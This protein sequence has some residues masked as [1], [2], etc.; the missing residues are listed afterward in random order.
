MNVDNLCLHQ[1]TIRVWRQSSETRQ[2][3]IDEEKQNFLEGS[4]ENMLESRQNQNSDSP[5]V[6]TLDTFN[7]MQS[8]YLASKVKVQSNN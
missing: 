2:A 3:A 6:G 4:F 7:A 1:I 5:K 8:N